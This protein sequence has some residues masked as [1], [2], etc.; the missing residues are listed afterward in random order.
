MK[1]LF[2][3]SLFIFVFWFLFFINSTYASFPLGIAV[4]N[5]ISSPQCSKYIKDK[6]ECEE[7]VIK[8]EKDIE[9]LN[10]KIN[11]LKKEVK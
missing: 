4:G 11:V 2:N 8:L 7:K 5:A 10:N 1:F 3:F 6:K 9:E